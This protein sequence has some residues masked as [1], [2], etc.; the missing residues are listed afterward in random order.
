M[1]PAKQDTHSNH[2][3][4]ALVK[5]RRGLS[6][7]EYVIILALIAVAAIATWRSFGNA[8]IEKVGGHQSQV[9]GL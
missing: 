7:V 6:T 3:S 4:T 5:D 1:K 2:Q 8:I 9:E